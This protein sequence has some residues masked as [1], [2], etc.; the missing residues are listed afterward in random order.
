MWLQLTW[1][2]SNRIVKGFCFSLI[3]AA[4]DRIL[5]SG[6]VKTVANLL[7]GSAEKVLH[8]DKPEKDDQKDAGKEDEGK[9]SSQRK[10]R[11]IQAELLREAGNAAGQLF[12]L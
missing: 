5:G 2:S 4:K 11:S 10:K 7:L 12:G 8:P 1:I 3:A 9:E 6:G